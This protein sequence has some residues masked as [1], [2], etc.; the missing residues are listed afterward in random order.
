MKNLKKLSPVFYLFIL[1]PVIALLNS[2]VV[3]RP[4]SFTPLT[5][6]D[7]VQMSKDKVPP[8]NIINEIKR[9]HTAYILKVEEFAKLQQAGIADTVI[10]FMEQTHIDLARHEQQVQDSYY[11]YPGYGSYWNG[12]YGWPWAYWGWNMGSNFIFRGGGGYHGYG[13]G[14]HG[15]GGFRGGGGFHGGGRHR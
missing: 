15:G 10:N 1:V 6:P 11:Y 12:G 8:G 4:N 14:F 7:I 9:S 3:Y 13:G 2:C 5:V